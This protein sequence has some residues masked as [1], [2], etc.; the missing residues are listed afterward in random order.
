MANQVTRLKELLFDSE[1]RALSDLALRVDTVSREGQR[2][3][4]DLV[5]DIERRSESERR[6]AV[7]LSQRID[8]AFERAGSDDRLKNSVAAIIDGALVKAETQRHDQ[9]AQAIAPLVVR[10]VRTEIRNSQDTLVEA[11]YPM[12]GRMVKAYVASAMKDL[13]ADINRRL[14]SNA[15][16]LRL[17]SLA[18]GHSVGELALAEAH[19]LEVEELFLIRRGTGALVDHWPESARTR[20]RDQVVSGI[21]AAIN[22]FA[23]EAFQGEGSALRKVD[24]EGSQVYLRASPEYLLAV[25]CAGTAPRAIEKVIDDEF[26]AT[27]EHH[28]AELVAYP[29]G[30]MPDA[31]RSEL[32]AGLSK[33]LESSIEEKRSELLAPP[34][35]IRPLPLAAALLALMLVTAAGWYGWRTIATGQVRAVAQRTLETSPEIKGY[36]VTV[37]VEPWGHR[38]TISG[39]TPSSST[40]ED[41]VAR[42]R[43]LLPSTEITDRLAVVPEGAPDTRP[44]IARI[45]RDVARLQA[46][47][48]RATVRRMLERASRRLEAAAPDLERLRVTHPGATSQTMAALKEG[49]DRLAVIRRTLADGSAQRGGETPVAAKMHS[50]AH[51]LAN[52][53]AALTQLLG[54]S[55]SPRVAL[56]SAPGASLVDAADDVAAESERLAAIVIAVVQADV[57][58]RKPLPP[59]VV[60]RETAPPPPPAPT[61]PAPSARDRL[62]AWLPTHA[63]FFS[64]DTTYRN[65]DRAGHT[66]DELASLLRETNV[67]VRVVGFTDEVGTAVRNNP[68]SQQ[69]ASRVA[70]DLAER[71]VARS[72]LI[73]VGRAQHADISTV[74]GPQSPNRRVEFEPAFEGETE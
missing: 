28:H 29:P 21:L 12:T 2:R 37:E 44:E 40:H 54:E 10:T 18:T 7:D 8:Q 67:I 31:D 39:L 25:R 53:G 30:A 20:D 1:A 51:D 64:N 74:T 47:A 48:D 33:R 27:I 70:D 58:G 5:R 63:V 19:R 38:L 49:I 41:I 23:T 17:R 15:L 72:R 42:L 22:D 16:M 3:H 61:P 59:P 4:D 62:M 68:L 26:L 13:V 57:V 34:F 35:G 9:L 24:L 56:Q 55:V 60:I 69:R 36:P 66:L 46:E 11:L 73:V 43:R 50:I 52:A 32:L 45:D 6:L 71:G 14:E 65:P